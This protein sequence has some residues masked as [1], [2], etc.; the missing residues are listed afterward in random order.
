MNEGEGSAVKVRL[1]SF[2]HPRK[3][4]F[5]K[6]SSLSGYKIWPSHVPARRRRKNCVSFFFSQWNSTFVWTWGIAS[7][8]TTFERK[9]FEIHTYTNQ[10]E[11]LSP[12]LLCIVRTLQQWSMVQGLLPLVFECKCNQAFFVWG[13]PLL[14]GAKKL[15]WTIMFKLTVLSYENY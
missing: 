15:Y 10:F 12:R 8:V 1:N 13:V 6:L 4:K 3:K 5:P 7:K 9:R 2:P 11:K 14:R